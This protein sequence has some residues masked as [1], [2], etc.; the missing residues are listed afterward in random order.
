MPLP[1][2]L[3]VIVLE[4][5]LN[6]PLAPEDGAVKVTEKPGTGLLNESVTV[7]A[8]GFGNAVLTVVICGVVPEFAAME[9]AAAGETVSVK[10]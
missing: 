9:L 7:T 4:L 8:S 10:D 2:V 3:T 6:V 1:F 5:L